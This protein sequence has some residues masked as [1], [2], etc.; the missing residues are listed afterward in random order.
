MI[1]WARRALLVVL[2][3]A[4]SACTLDLDVRVAVEADG[5]G[6]VEVTAAVDAGA[7]HRVGGDLAAAL[8]LDRLRGDGWTVDGPSNTPD[9][10]ATVTL[11]QPFADAAEA[12]QVFAELAGPGA[13]SPFRDLRVGRSRSTFE[14]RWSFG[15]TI[16][17][18]GGVPLPDLPAAS[19]VDPLPDD[20]GALEA[21]LGESLDRLLRLRVGVRLPGDVTS[22]ATTRADN[23]A[24]WLVRFGDGPVELDATGTRTKAAP[25][26]LIAVG[27]VG[28][29]VGL[30][31][32]LVRLAGRTTAPDGTPAR[33]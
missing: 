1:R 28:L 8:D 10:G 3:A 4:L 13:R 25:Y 16:D 18:R 27:A 23:G 12:R 5:S 26:V 17:L 22:N 9:G 11:R 21:Q 32:L 15:G 19:G 14:D 2:L 30:V 20:V 33:R 24:V 29:L 31:V 6:T 7:L